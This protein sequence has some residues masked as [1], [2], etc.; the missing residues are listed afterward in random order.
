MIGAVIVLL[1]DLLN[2][3]LKTQAGTGPEESQEDRV[4]FLDGER[5]DEVAFKSGAI[6]A[7]L[8]NLEEESTLRSADLYRGMNEQGEITDIFPEIRLNLYVLFVARFKQYDK[9]LQ[10]LS[11]IISFFRAH[12]VLDH[13]NAPALDG[14][15]DR[16]AIELITL[17][18]SE[19]NEV[20]SSLRT[21]YH[22]SVLY[23]V[24]LLAFRDEGAPAAS[25]VQD[26]AI[27]LNEMAT[28]VSR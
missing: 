7:I 6:T 28:E 18:F 15:I 21:A 3:Y 24:K 16:L 1:K 8:V 26:V 13:R 9:G 22:P 23:R 14:S 17:P 20:W 12:R 5:L 10:H 4:V 11:S 2:D 27:E 19:Q 25:E